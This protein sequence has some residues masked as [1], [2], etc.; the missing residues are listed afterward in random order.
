MENWPRLSWAQKSL[1][2][3]QQK[4]QQHKTTDGV[5]HVETLGPGQFS[6]I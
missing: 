3:Q 6:A 4:Q 5:L 2:Q 1:K